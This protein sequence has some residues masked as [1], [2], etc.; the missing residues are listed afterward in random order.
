MGGALSQGEFGSMMREVFERSTDA[1]FRWERW[2]TLRG[3]RMHVFAYTVDQARSKWTID[4]QKQERLRELLR[5]LES[6]VI[7]GSMPNEALFDVEGSAAQRRS[8]SA[9]LR[10]RVG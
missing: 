1:A 7:N 6:T 3:R 8:A 2:A 9:T 10:M 4:Y 5:D